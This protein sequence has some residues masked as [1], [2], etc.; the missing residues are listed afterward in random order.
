MIGMS[1]NTF[2]ERQASSKPRQFRADAG[3]SLALVMRPSR[4]SSTQ[5]SAS[6]RGDSAQPRPVPLFA[7][8]AAACR[9]GPRVEE[10]ADEANGFGGLG[11]HDGEAGEHVPGGSG[12]DGRLVSRRGRR[13]P[14]AR[15]PAARGAG[16]RADQAEVLA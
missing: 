1:V 12:G 9:P 7:G 6:P 5:A 4:P 15:Q 11:E 10:L 16:H 13:A 3:R 14:G 8:A 2:C